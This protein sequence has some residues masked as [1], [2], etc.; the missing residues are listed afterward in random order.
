MQPRHS[1]VLAGATI[2]K[3]D[4]IRL[5]HVGDRMLAYPVKSTHSRLLLPVAVNGA[6]R[7]ELVTIRSR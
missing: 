1:A 2:E 3:G 4:S 6:R 5:E 7:G